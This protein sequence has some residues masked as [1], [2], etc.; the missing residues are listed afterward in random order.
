M[1]LAKNILP[2]A[3]LLPLAIAPLPAAE[4]HVSPKGDD[5]NPG[6]AEKPFAT[7]LA[8]QKSVRTAAD[9]PGSAIILHAGVY[10]LKKSLE[11]SEAD[12]GTREKP[13]V[14]KAAPGESVSVIGGVQVPAAAI[15]R[16]TDANVLSRVIEESG[17]QG[18][19]E[20]DL[21]AIGVGDCGEVGPRGFMR[22]YIPAPVEIAIDGE[23][24]Q[25]A[26]WPNASRAR[27]GS[28]I[29]KG[30]VPRIGEKPDRGGKFIVPDRAEK[31][32][33][34]KD[35]FLFGYFSNNY[36]D[37]TVKVA[38]VS[39]EK[40]KDKAG[41]D[42]ERIVL[43]TGQPHLYGF[44]GG[45]AFIA[46]NLIEEIDMPG[47]YAFDRKAGK[48]YLLPPAG[49]KL[50]AAQVVVTTLKT[51]LLSFVNASN[52]Q[53]E[54]VTLESTRGIGA[55]IEGGQAIRIGK[56]TL[57]NIGMVAVCMG[58]GTDPA[59]IPFA[60]EAKDILGPVSGAIGGLYTHF[61]ADTVFDRKAGT[62][63]GV[64]GCH[65]YNTG[66]GGVSLGGGERKSLTPGNNFVENCRIHDFNRWEESYRGAVNLDGVGNRVSHCEIYDAPGCA[67]FLHGNEHIIEN[68]EIHHVM[69]VAGDMGAFYMGRDPTERGNIIRYNYWHDA[70]LGGERFCLYFDDTG[71]DASKVYGNIFN[72]TGSFGTIFMPGGSDFL[73]ENNTFIDCHKPLFPKKRGGAG[74]LS[75]LRAAAVGY[76][77]SPWRERYPEFLDY[78]EP[79]VKLPRR[80]VY[81]N[82]LA[83]VTRPPTAT[84][85]IE[86][87]RP[88]YWKTDSDP[89][90]VNRAA[91][92]FRFK[93]DAEAF[94]KLPGFKPGDISKMGLLEEP[95]KSRK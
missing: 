83:V 34:A 67:L 38:G 61:Y 35:A 49:K 84:E 56:S 36:A 77:K 64:S 39:R 2:F 71:G 19:L 18:L 53:W 55:Y 68:S 4:F 75:R 41:K 51:P 69:K 30:A 76:D 57:R 17:K 73:I 5:A 8:A 89:G 82:N 93:P 24:L 65:I 45:R 32:T 59:E 85:P 22:P 79:G 94:K 86:S 70:A 9:R 66:E 50:D 21:T 13:V 54:G 26:R 47:E 43:T 87:I 88:G 28:V 25:I 42:I 10:S 91:G 40:M 1:N 7:L 60:T 74:P 90:F 78:F 63:H 11:F 72:K 27:T 14:W 80:N 29:E 33:Q 6:T 37:D 16:V 23:P 92:D 58:R 44:S 95:W 15:K 46:K 48:L 3:A 52:I 20:I 12:S 31:W 81:H 62:D